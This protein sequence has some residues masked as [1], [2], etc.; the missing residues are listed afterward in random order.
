ML[1]SRDFKFDSA[2]F[3]PKYHGKCERLHGHTYRLRVTLEGEPDSEGMVCDFAEIKKVVKE[4]VLADL[5]H[6]NLNDVMENPSAE[7]IAVW[8]WE[9]LQG[10]FGEAKLYEVKVWETENC[11]VSYRG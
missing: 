10:Q 4:R 5:D 9:K 8:I 11:F 3:L 1:V 2:H 7:N 6:N